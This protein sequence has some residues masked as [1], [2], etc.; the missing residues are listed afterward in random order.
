MHPHL[1]D[2]HHR[3]WRMETRRSRCLELYEGRRSCHLRSYSLSAV[4]PYALIVIHRHTEASPLIRDAM[5]HPRLPKAA[6]TALRKALCPPSTLMILP[7]LLSRS[8]TEVSRPATRLVKP[9]ESLSACTLHTNAWPTQIP[10]QDLASL[11]SWSKGEN[12]VHSLIRHLS[13]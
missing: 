3:Q 6:G 8:S 2:I 11:T 13:S 9:K 12:R 1:F 10:R 5:P 7:S 4:C